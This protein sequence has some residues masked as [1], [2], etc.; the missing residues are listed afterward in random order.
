VS[1]E[2]ILRRTDDPCTGAV[3]LINGLLWDDITEFPVLGETEVWSFVNRS[4]IVHPMHMHLVSFQVLD[5]QAFDVID[6]VVVPI[7]NPVPP[8]PNEQGWKD[9]VRAEPQQITRVIARFEDFAGKFAYHC[10]IL[11]HEDHEM[12][13]QFLT[14]P[15]CIGDLDGSGAIGFGDLTSL[16]NA[17]GPT[18][19]DEHWVPCPADLN[20]DRSI[21]FA[22]L[23]IMLNSWGA[24]APAPDPM[25]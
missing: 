14:V 13:R 23:T 3:W 19:P 22:D 17:W 18:C 16:L 6:E 20:F 4:G 11:E 1:R 24:C 9:T 10:H 8:D 7:G 5:R 21:G 12:M 25:H 2:F 15:A